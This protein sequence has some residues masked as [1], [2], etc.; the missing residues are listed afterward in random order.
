MCNLAYVKKKLYLCTLNEKRPLSV[1]S[2]MKF[3]ALPI[4]AILF[5]AAAMIVQFVI[6]FSLEKEH[7]RETVE[8]KIEMRKYVL[9]HPFSEREL[10]EATRSELNRY[11]HIDNIF[12][13]F[14]PGVY[15]GKESNFFPRTYRSHGQTIT[16]AHGLDSLDYYVRD[17]YTGALRCDSNGYWSEPY[18]GASTQ[19]RIASHSIK[20]EDKQGRLI[21]VVG[22]DFSIEWIKDI[23]QDINPYDEAVCLIHSTDGTFIASSDS[24]TQE[25]EMLYKNDKLHWRVYSQTLYPINMQLMIAVPNY[26]IWQ[27]IK[28]RS[29]ITLC[30]LIIG[31]VVLV[32]LFRR[33]EMNQKAYFQVENE[34]KLIQNEMQIAKN[35]QRGI[36]VHDFIDDD[37]LSLHATLVPMQSV[38]GDLYDF[39][40]DGDYVTFIIGDVSGKGMP[41]AMFMSSTVTLFRATVKHHLSPNVIMGEINASLSANNSS[42]MFVTAFIGRLHLPTGQLTYCNAGHLPPLL[43]KNGQ[44]RWLEMKE[45]NVILGLDGA[46]HFTEQSTTLERG[47]QI[48][49]FT[50][51]VTEAENTKKELLGFDHLLELL[52]TAQ[53]P[54][55][56]QTIY[57]LVCRFSAGAEQSDDIAIM[58]ITRK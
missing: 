9:E 3:R 51:G 14:A 23:L 13:K 27:S 17:W 57:D 22:N 52:Q 54:I 10:L 31:I 32:L 30:V 28:G 53:P 42:M 41:A 19:T 40:R 56:D 50:D 21:G 34:H 33:I 8:Y 11:P 4:V 43:V 5:I 7:V 26:I 6:S 44:C 24:S 12:V 55:D 47:E 39:Y 25:N 18:I 46:Y 37:A 49:V 36:L 48:I 29:I 58:N 45:V 15:H 35:I 38:G 2:D 20:I 1:L 16:T